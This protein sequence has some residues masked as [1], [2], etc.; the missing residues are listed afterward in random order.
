MSGA[1][2]TFCT[3]CGTDLAG[4]PL[5]PGCGRDYGDALLG[6]VL[7]GKVRV[8]A[9]IGVGGYGRVYR[10]QHLGL[11]APVAIKFLLAEWSLLPELR[12]R[13]QRE[14]AALGRL[15]HP[16]IVSVLDF[17]Q[18]DGLL[19]MVLELLSGHTL[20]AEMAGDKKARLSAARIGR[21]IDQVLEALE[22]AHAAGIVHRDLKPENIMLLDGADDRVKVL[23][24][25][26]AL[27]HGGSEN[28]RLTVTGAVQGTPRYMSPEQCRGRDVGAPTDVYAVGVLLYE[29]LAGDAPFAGQ[30]ASELMAQQM[31]VAPPSLTDP[32]I[33][34]GLAALALRALAKD[35]AARP[36]ASE[37]RAELAL[38]LS[39][40]DDASRTARGAAARAVA[41]GLS[42]SER[43][44]PAAAAPT[45]APT[46]GARVLLWMNDARRARALRDALAVNGVVGLVHAAAQL[47][48]E[49][50]SCQAAIVLADEGPVERLG[51]L[52][53]D[54]RTTRTPV[55]VADAQA[56]ETPALIR[57]G[58]NDVTLLA[59]GDELVAQKVARLIR[60]GR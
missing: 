50:P 42:R 43:A 1:I 14:A 15:R 55:L 30:S 49:L 17:G 52:H 35:P 5:C 29:L 7:D 37:M 18:H 41:G 36:T 4:Q 16:T 39:G 12:T 34:P 13:F 28:P 21:I 6:V 32:A 20:T 24:F 2:P 27:V 47:P 19:Y 57:G 53:A 58:A 25:G 11:G 60:R 46:A 48:D 9:L 23:D 54:G 40:G 3:S 44:L 26:I 51:A 56:D 33:A 38:A 31:Y 45:A 8:D 22:V 10:G 59:V